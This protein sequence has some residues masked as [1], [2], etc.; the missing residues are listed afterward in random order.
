MRT[1]K[2][3]L[4][5]CMVMLSAMAIW[6]GH[7]EVP[8]RGELPGETIAVRPARSTPARGYE[9]VA[10]SDESV[11][12]LSPNVV[13]ADADG[14]GF[15]RSSANGAPAEVT[16][17]PELLERVRA[18]SA[19]DDDRFVVFAGSGGGS[20]IKRPRDIGIG[21]LSAGPRVAPG[22]IPALPSITLAVGETESDLYSVHVF[23]QGASALRSYQVALT[24]AGGTS[25]R[26]ALE[27]VAID[28][29]RPDYVFA[30]LEAIAAADQVAGRAAG[31]LTGGEIGQANLAYL[32]TY[33]F[34]A[35]PDAAGACQVGVDLER[36]FLAN[37]HNEITEFRA[38]PP[39]VI[40][41]S[42]PPRDRREN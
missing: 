37:G 42:A 14:V 9:K 17:S 22:P 39:A 28:E 40:E 20:S 21:R 35:S 13:A 23:E 30:G 41:V 15:E 8:T 27:D 4:R 36:S 25:S 11:I 16:L 12:Y 24:L 3:K 6:S 1:T 26:L 10:F 31:V 2:D 18:A 33:T 34:R 5:S 32:A 7:A 19:A 38:D 29:D